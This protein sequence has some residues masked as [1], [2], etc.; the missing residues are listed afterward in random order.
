MMSHFEMIDL[1]YCC[2]VGAAAQMLAG[3]HQLPNSK[4]HYYVL[5]L[6]AADHSRTLHSFVLR[7]WMVE[8]VVA[9]DCAMNPTSLKELLLAAL[10]ASSCLDIVAAVGVAAELDAAAA[11]DAE[12]SDGVAAVLV[13]PC[14]SRVHLPPIHCF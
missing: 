3:C 9:A 8:A 7:C 13:V 14:R 10:D 12:A 11:P 2:V 4:D 1:C 5:V 6:P